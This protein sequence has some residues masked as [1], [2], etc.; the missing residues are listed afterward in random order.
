[1]YKELLEK[2]V[3]AGASSEQVE[4]VFKM[5]K[6]NRDGFPEYVFKRMERA[7]PVDASGWLKLSVR[8]CLRSFVD[9][10]KQPVVTARKKINQKR[11]ETM[12]KKKLLQQEDSKTDLLKKEYYSLSEA[13]KEPYYERVKQENPETPDFLI[14]MK[15]FL[16][17]CRDAEEKQ[18]KG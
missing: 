5:S 6:Y 1:M 10:G 12:K 9:N 13:E 2:Y 18:K 11:S 15:A 3:E 17:Y 14:K 8:Y 7:N 16:L 4:K